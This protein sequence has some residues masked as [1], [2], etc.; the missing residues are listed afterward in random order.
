[1]DFIYSVFEDSKGDLWVGTERGGLN[2][3]D[4]DSEQFEHFRHQA[5]VPN[6]LSH[7]EVWVI[8]ED[9]EGVLWVGTLT[10]LNKYD[11]KT[12][13]FT[14]YSFDATDQRS[15]SDSRIT[16]IYDDPQGTLWV[17]T[18]G[19]GINRFDKKT[20]DFTRFS[21]VDADPHSLGH[22]LVTSIYQ[23]SRG[24]LWVGTYG[25]GLN[26]FDSQTGG[27]VQYREK[28]GLANDGVYGIVEDSEGFLWISTNQGLSK[29]DLQTEVFR[30]YS[31]V[32]GLQSNEFNYGA[33]FI[34]PRGEIFFGGGNGFNRFFAQDI[35]D[36]GHRPKIAF[37]E[38]LLF[39]QPVPIGPS[40]AES[41]NFTLDKTINSLDRLRLGYQQ[42][43]MSFSFSALD[44]SDPKHNQYAYRLEGWDRDWI[45]TSAKNRRATY[46]NIP[47]G[48]YTLRVRAS[49]ADGFWNNE[50]KSLKISIAP[51]PWK[52]WWAK[53]FYGVFIIGLLL[54]F[55]HAQRRK[56]R[57]HQQKVLDEQAINQQ[58]K[59]VDKL[60]DEFLANTSHELRTPLNGI[61]GLTESLIDGV[62]GQLPEL[63]N[64]NLSMVV[65][66]GKRLANL[67]NDILDF[68]KLKN[69]ILNI[70]AKAMDV[71]SLVEVVLTLSLPLMKEK[72]LSCVNNISDGL[73]PVLADENRVQQILHNLVGNAIKFS[74]NG[75]IIIAGE[76]VG[77]Q[78]KISVTD[79]GIGIP[80]DKFDTIF[81]SFEQLEG[82][83]ARSYSGT[84]LGLAVSKQ[85]VELHGGQIS[86]ESVV[87]KG[88]VFSFTLPMAAIGS[89]VVKVTDSHC[90][91]RLH[92]VE[93][94]LSIASPPQP[95][96]SCKKAVVPSPN[97]SFRIL[98]VDDEPVNLQV[99]HNHLSME[100][101]Q[102]VGVESGEKALMMLK[103]EGPF[104]LV[105]LD[106]MMPKISGYEVCEKLRKIWP[107]H[108][109]PVIFL[110]AKNQ[111]SDLVESF[112]VGANDYL[113]KPIA[114]HELLKRVETHLMLLD[115]NRNL[116]HKVAQRT[117]AL[118][119]ATHAKS[120][121]LAKM[122]HEI[123]TPM[124]AVIGLSRLALKTK[125]DARQQDYIE[126]VVDAGESL[127]GLINDILDFSK[128]E[129]GKLSI[130]NIRFNLDRLLQ[131]SITLS[132]MNAHMKG[133][134][135]VTDVD[136]DIPSVMIGD[137]L[138][139]QQIIV[140]LINNAVKFTDE[141][142]VCVKMTIE[143]DFE[144]HLLLH[145]AVIDTGIGMSEKQQ[146]R[147]FKSFS[148]ADE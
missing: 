146:G 10:G 86:V 83:A 120:D 78:V 52:T 144:E 41:K 42:D 22:N 111:V 51:A 98:L 129:A 8:T 44:F 143:Q 3:F 127:L 28:D 91:S 23:D 64:H 135:L 48:H 101:Y 138:R 40:S 134:E 80:A 136:S 74:Q 49:N 61:I 55:V 118:E 71:K 130:E 33:Y 1:H 88:S 84:G 57:A 27:F 66:S 47:A 117:V 53:T 12:G 31:A 63:A 9:A 115:V 46:T 68:S 6:S 119:R 122:S 20:G 69:H 139:L 34:S 73:A 58:L 72:K 76:V 18:L 19:G 56:V 2:R 15:L 108:E 110:T 25:G 141:G 16:A 30:N 123:R 145:C 35:K 132:A 128:I 65:A 43:L 21:H 11:P 85:L 116:E 142:L 77:E 94:P 90:V 89:A 93:H 124:N 97:K 24:I 140:N 126:K 81:E 104:D 70:D 96:L 37:T 113:S 87:G 45:M 29:F 7:D 99:L 17:G 82:E 54:S 121:F 62:A 50:G 148:Q 95:V 103:D 5:N 109:L 14:L 67:V 131:R 125:L 147:M 39:N 4:R 79:C 133:I 100:N 13:G 92:M 26:K 105:L 112:S 59:Q 38:F 114:K 137:P 32:D 75:K 102:L 60:K 107:V 106:I 36:N